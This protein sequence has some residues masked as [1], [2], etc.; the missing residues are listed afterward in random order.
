MTSFSRIV[1]VGKGDTNTMAY[2]DN[3]GVTWTGLGKV[4]TAQSFDVDYSEI[5]DHWLAVGQGGNWA[6]YSTNGIDW[7]GI[8]TTRLTRGYGVATNGNRWVVVGRGANNKNRSI[9]YSDNGING[10]K[11]INNSR[12]DIFTTEAW[13]V[14]VSGNNWV[15]VGDGANHMIAYSTDNAETWTHSLMADGSNTDVLFTNK[16][17]TVSTNGSRW[18]AGGKS[19]NPLGYSDDNGQ[20]W[21]IV[22]DP[23]INTF[24][25]THEIFGSHWDGERFWIS[26]TSTSIKL[27]YSTDGLNWSQFSG[28][29]YVKARTFLSYDNVLFTAGD[30]LGTYSSAISIDNGNSFSGGIS[31]NE[32][33]TGSGKTIYGLARKYT[34][35]PEPNFA[36]G[37][38]MPTKIGVTDQNMS[39]PLGRKAFLRNIN[40]SH[41]II[42][43]GK[44]IDYSSVQNSIS[45]NIYAKPIGNNSTSLRIQRLRLTATGHNSSRVGNKN[46]KIILG[47]A[48]KN[49]VTNTLSRVRGSGGMRVKR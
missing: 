27:A 26:G 38:T 32:L 5:Q 42:N 22:D 33:F 16:G 49:F 46:E 28:S 37:V 41:K 23:I 20:T 44:N 30:S 14:A 15:A 13:D 43:T 29:Y 11:N 17:I 24:S 10:W 1:A 12:S 19:T 3:S 9:V 39:F 2:S 4:F 6:V 31:V 45:S 35:E 48:D 21:N 40:E 36:T 25:G 7:K 47:K 34:P 18:I 8:T